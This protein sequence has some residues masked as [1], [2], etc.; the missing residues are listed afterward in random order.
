MHH[1][2]NYSHIAD[3]AQRDAKAL[4]DTSTFLGKKAFDTLTEQFKAKPPRGLM[5]FTLLCSFAGIQGYP[6]L[7]WFKHIFPDAPCL[8]C[9]HD[10]QPIPEDRDEQGRLRSISMLG[11]HKCSKCGDYNTLAADGS[12]PPH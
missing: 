4:S 1:T 7:A 11:T 8:T 12:E 2:I 6:A 10:W 3:V 9:E 5:E